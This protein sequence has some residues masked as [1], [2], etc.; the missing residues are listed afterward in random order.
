MDKF[1]MGI[2]IETGGPHMGNNPLLAVGLCVYKLNNLGLQLQSTI[3]IHFEGDINK[4][5][6]QTLKFWKENSKSWEYI[7]K[8]CV[9]EEEGAKRLI[10]FVKKWQKKAFD[11]NTDFCIVTDNC[12]FDD[13]WISN[14]FSKYGGFPLRHN[15][16]TGYTKLSH[17]IDINQLMLGARLAGVKIPKFE[18][19]NIHDHTPVNDAKKIVEKYYNFIKYTNFLKKQK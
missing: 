19:K 8:D 2:D 14:L 5:D 4:Y 13:T 1:I 7:K 16:Y 18:Y 6:K 9:L 10:N 17:V 12:W 3:E 15:N 11:K